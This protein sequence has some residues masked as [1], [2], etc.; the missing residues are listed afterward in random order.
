MRP[1]YERPTRHSVRYVTPGFPAPASPLR[2]PS[3]APDVCPPPNVPAFSLSPAQKYK[4]SYPFHS[5]IILPPVHRHQSSKTK[6]LF[7]SASLFCSTV[8]DLRNILRA[9]YPQNDIS[10]NTSDHLHHRPFCTD[11]KPLLLHPPTHQPSSITYRLSF[12]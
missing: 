8:H 5:H 6:T 10:I 2:L 9:P 11:L 1:W 12:G 3:T 4:N 7:S